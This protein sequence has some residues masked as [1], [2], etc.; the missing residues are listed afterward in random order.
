MRI[1]AVVFDLY[2]TL[3][4]IRT[5]EGDPRVYEEVS[6]FLGYNHVNVGA[7][8]LRDSYLRKIREHLSKSKEDHPDVNV[9]KVFTEILHEYGEGRMELRLPLYTARLFRSLTR[10][11]FEPFPGVYG[12]LERLRDQYSLGLLSDAQRCYT[13]PEIRELK[14]DWFF[15]LML[16]SS[17]HGHRKPEPKYFRQALDSLGV[18]A[19]D[20][21]YVG[22]NPQRDLVGAKR[23]GMRMVLVRSTDR[24]YEGY[25]ADAA[26]ADIAEL[27]PVLDSLSHG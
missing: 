1:K 21:V 7:E 26:I 11:V 2:G 16:L 14:L 8:E 24:E 19:S 3:I 10:R 5:D 9:M 6:K 20:A 23:A 17:D 12:M 22:D 25:A 4:N 13:E 18:R 15:D 27:E